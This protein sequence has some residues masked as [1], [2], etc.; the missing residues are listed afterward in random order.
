M[1]CARCKEIIDKKDRWVSIRDFNEGKMEK[2]I[3]LHLYC[4]KEMYNQKITKALGQK[5]Q[6]IMGM[7]GGEKVVKIQ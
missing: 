3:N 6:D 4:W 5:V 2:E 7:F 1:I